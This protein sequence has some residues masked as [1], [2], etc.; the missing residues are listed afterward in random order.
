MAEPK[1]D[2]IATS[3]DDLHSANNKISKAT[4]LNE[5]GELVKCAATRPTC[6]TS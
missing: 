3:V 6:T 5:K 1:G 2:V 4:A